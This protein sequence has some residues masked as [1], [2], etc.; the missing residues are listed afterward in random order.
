MISNALV[1]GH[2]YVTQTIVT[3][4]NIKEDTRGVKYMETYCIVFLVCLHVQNSSTIK[5]LLNS[6][7]IL[8]SY[9]RS[10]EVI[11]LS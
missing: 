5:D 6:F 4:E 3:A 10:L 8:F 11:T 2:L 1:L 7:Q 9:V